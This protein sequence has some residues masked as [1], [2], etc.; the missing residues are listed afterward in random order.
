MHER[1]R[2]HD[3]G[4]IRSRSSETALVKPSSSKNCDRKLDRKDDICGRLEAYCSTMNIERVGKLG[5]G[6]KS[7]E[8]EGHEFY[9][10]FWQAY[11]K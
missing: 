11:S 1:N 6:A 8:N 2:F 3:V 10:T 7:L 5:V 9:F 4:S